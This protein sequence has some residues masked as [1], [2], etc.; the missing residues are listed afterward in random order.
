MFEIKQIEA[1]HTYALRQKVLMPDHSID[2]C[3]YTRDK[4]EETLHIGA[5]KEETLIGTASF[6]KETHEKMKQK[7]VYRL[8]GLAIDPEHRNQ[9]RGQTLLLFAENKLTQLDAAMLWCTTSVKNVEYYQHLG[10]K[11]TDHRFHLPSK[12]LNVLMVK[13]L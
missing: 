11:E 1:E 2:E 8:R 9:L 4:K 3:G 5:F 10:F 13:P 7:N 6:F 12:G